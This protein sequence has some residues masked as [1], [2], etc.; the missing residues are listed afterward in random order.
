MKLKIYVAFIATIMLLSCNDDFL[1]KYPKDSVNEKS[2]WNTAN[3]LKT[4]NNH[5]YHQAGN[6]YRYMFYMG[7][8]NSAWYSGYY[9]MFWE[10]CKSDNMAPK[11]GRLDQ[12]AKIAA[13]IHTVPDKKQF[14]G[15]YWE[16]LRICNVFLENYE[17]VE[18]P[19][20]VKN[21]YAGEVRLWR[22]WF[23]WDKVKRFG[24][25][26][27][28]PTALDIDSPEL[29]GERNDRSLV[30]DH[31]LED[32]NF[33]VEHMSEDWYTSDP[34]RLNRWTALA[35]KARV[36]LHEGTFR[37]YHGLA[38]AEK[39]LSHAA[40][41]AE[42]LINNGPYE[43]FNTGN[44]ETDYASLFTQLDLSGHKEV[45]LARKYITGTLGH[46]FKG[47]YGRKNGATK[48]L[49]EDY[50][51]T[52][53]LPAQLSNVYQG[54]AT[55][56]DEFVNRD[57]RMAQTVVVPGTAGPFEGIG[58]GKL[59]APR[60]IG[61]TGGGFITTT[62]YPPA[63]FFEVSDWRKGYGKEE[64]DAPVIR[65]AEVLLAFAEAKAELGTITQADL[66]KSINKL[67]DRAGM[68]HLAVNPP[69]DPKYE[70]EDLSSIIVEIRR[71]RRIEL[72]FEGYRY[73]DL[74]RWKKG[75]YLAKTVIGMRLE[76]DQLARYPEA[77]IKR[78]EIDGKKYIDVYQGSDVGNRQFD[79][80]KHYLM[81]LPLSEISMNPTL[82]Q[83]P[84][85]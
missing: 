3:D 64:N 20:S 7:F 23:Y 85:W 1:E 32:L 59:P 75:S 47:Y 25:V 21:M 84:G 41:A 17:K 8:T 51:C 65:F 72:A 22:A 52:D 37:K 58:W 15:W 5:L 68:P 53:G 13:G 49:I 30:M 42:E 18:E 54:D 31:V 34:D 33:A 77:N 9:G 81:P 56:E 16:F 44:P 28:I 60:L 74:M 63:K 48:S 35:L 70:N 67:R 57:P 46:R 66:D 79:E 80:N 10:D 73:D 12:Y 83:N 76:D 45:V 82:G 4:Y 26:P 40:S 78:I 19:E 14:G 6:V 39:F 50:L 2:F 69:M 62:G 27:W 38:E 29:L 55:I 36:C 24:N 11:D 61:Q 71:E 43:I